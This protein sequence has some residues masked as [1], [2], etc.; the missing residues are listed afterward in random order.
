MAIQVFTKD[1]WTVN[2]FVAS[3]G[4]TWFRGKDVATILGCANSKQTL[5]QLVDTEDK[6]KLDELRGINEIP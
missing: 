1:E 5:I 4:E 6:K 3:E 2:C